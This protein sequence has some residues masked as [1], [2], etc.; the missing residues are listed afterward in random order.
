MKQVLKNKKKLRQ[1]ARLH[2]QIENLKATLEIY[3]GKKK[4]PNDQRG[5][6]GPA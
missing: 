1:I 3:I 5:K 2:E 6:E 4:E